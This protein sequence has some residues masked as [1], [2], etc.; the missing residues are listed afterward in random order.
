MILSV[1]V[2]RLKS[3]CVHQ[4][5]GCSLGLE[6]SRSRLDTGAQTSRYRPRS[7]H[8]AASHLHRTSKLKLIANLAKFAKLYLII[9]H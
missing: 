1:G 8:H 5:R 6:A 3:F 7:R 2:L 4:I 9:I